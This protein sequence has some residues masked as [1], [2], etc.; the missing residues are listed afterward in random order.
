MKFFLTIFILSI[1][2]SFSVFSQVSP[3]R[4]LRINTNSIKVIEGY[5]WDY[6]SAL[7]TDVFNNYIVVLDKDSSSVKV[8]SL[9][10]NYKSAGT[11]NIVNVDS[12]NR[13]I[14]FKGNHNFAEV[15]YSYKWNWDKAGKLLYTEE[16]IN[17]KLNKKIKI[18]QAGAGQ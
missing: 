8:L 7:V 16:Y 1:V 17:G 10:K 13:P 15:K 5:P 18:N 2:Y 9:I 6:D 3:L 11:R 4:K 12:M 14:S